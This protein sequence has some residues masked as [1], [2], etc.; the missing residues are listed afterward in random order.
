MSDKAVSFQSRPDRLTR[1]WWFLLLFVL[2]NLIPPYVSKPLSSKEWSEM[3][4]IYDHIFSNA[5]I[6]ALSSPWWVVFQ[7]APVVLV[8]LIFLLGNR[9]RAVFS[10]YAAITFVLFAVLQNIA[11]TKKYGLGIVTCNFL[12]FMIL[13]GFWA[14]EAFAGLT[15][16]SPRRRPLWAYW[17]VPL[18]IFAFWIPVGPAKDGTWHFSPL[19]F[20]QMHTGL[21]FC[22][23]A[24]VYLAIL[25]LYHLRVNLAVMRMT[26]LTGI[27][28]AFYNILGASFGR[29]AFHAI[30]HV[31]LATISIYAFVLSFVRCRAQEAR[32][33]ESPCARMPWK[34]RHHGLYIAPGR[35]GAGFR[36]TRRGRQS[37]QP[38]QLRRRAA[39]DRGL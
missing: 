35:R 21:A 28:L 20:L 23:M 25:S 30:A 12:W 38:G 3:W 36:L 7:I 37:L 16:F 13:A 26:A 24:P 9:V 27:I 19:F 8:L 33:R 15:D 6:N 18:A 1:R 14:W 32:S 10:A 17:V 31:P 39:A 4:R 5:F 22:L 34:G 2:L 29:N 11:V